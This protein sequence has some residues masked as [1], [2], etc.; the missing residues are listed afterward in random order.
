MHQS[1]AQNAKRFFD[2]YSAFLPPDPVVVDIGSMNINGGIRDV[3]PPGVK[4]VGIDFAEGPGVDYVMSDPYQVPIHDGQVDVVT[5][6]S[7]FEHSPMFWLLFLDVL[8]VLKPTGLFYLNVPSNGAFHRHPVDCWRFYPDAADALAQ[9][10][11]RNNL[12]TVFLESWWSAKGTDGSEWNDFVAVFLK[13]AQ[14]ADLFPNRIPYNLAADGK[15]EW[16]VKPNE[17]YN[18]RF[19]GWADHR[20]LDLQDFPDGKKSREEMQNRPGVGSNK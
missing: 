9:W 14:H 13:D 17:I 5:A 18:G 1:A 6:S 19:H 16:K 8:R 3:C 20:I 4:F 7:T 15:Q 11:R 10:A 2:T 12:P